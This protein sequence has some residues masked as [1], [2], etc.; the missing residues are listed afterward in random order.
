MQVSRKFQPLAKGNKPAPG[1]LSIEPGRR[2]AFGTFRICDASCIIFVSAP[3]RVSQSAPSRPDG[4]YLQV[5]GL[6]AAS[7]LQ[8][9]L[10]TSA[11]CRAASAIPARTATVIRKTA[12]IFASK[13]SRT[14][15][16]SLQLS[17]RF[18]E[19]STC[20]QL[21]L[22]YRISFSIVSKFST[23]R[24]VFPCLLCYKLYKHF[25]L[26]ANFQFFNCFNFNSSC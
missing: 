18:R 20:E 17:T 24:V 22:F 14:A 21:N 1:E 15:G 6:L 2:L 9:S 13:H 19:I 10:S 4:A 12:F 7:C 26:I 16:R 11:A 23:K 8:P 25:N 3:L 5:S